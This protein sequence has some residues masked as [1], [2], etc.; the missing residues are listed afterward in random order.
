M[1]RPIVAMMD[2][3]GDVSAKICSSPNLDS[4]GD[5]MERPFA[6]EMTG[7][8]RMRPE[9]FTWDSPLDYFDVRQ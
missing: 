8:L 3:A 4:V 9:N 1:D 7:V 6:F 2:L 5:R